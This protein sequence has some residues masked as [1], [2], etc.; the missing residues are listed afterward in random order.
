MFQAAPL[1]SAA[2]YSLASQTL[3]LP[4]KF[5]VS[6]QRKIGEHVAKFLLLDRA[7][8]CDCRWTDFQ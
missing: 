7:A 3:G 5:K 2:A 4:A 6:R 1:V 8:H